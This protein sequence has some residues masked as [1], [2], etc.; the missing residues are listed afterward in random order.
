MEKDARRSLRLVNLQHYQ[1]V[2]INC[3]YFLEHKSEL[4]I[5]SLTKN[6]IIVQ[7]AQIIEHISNRASAVQQVGLYRHLFMDMHADLPSLFF[8]IVLV[9]NYLYMSLYAFHLGQITSTVLGQVDHDIVT[10][11]ESQ[12]GE[13]DRN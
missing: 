10:L 6:I 11:R 9:T 13:T 7:R 12:S 5:A 8:F 2:S 1:T 3:M 4:T